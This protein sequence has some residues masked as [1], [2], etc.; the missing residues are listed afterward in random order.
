LLLVA[1]FISLNSLFAQTGKFNY[2]LAKQSLFKKSE[3]GL[4]DTTE[5]T[6]QKQAV[7]KK[8]V[9]IGG[10]F[11]SF[12]GGL[13][14]PLNN[15]FANSSPAFGI[16]GRVEYSSYKIF[17]LVFGGEV[18]YFSYSGTDEFKTTNTLSIFN[19]KIFSYGICIEYT[20]AKMLNSSYT[21]PFVTIDIKSNSIRRTYDIDAVLNNVPRDESR[22]SVGAG[23][24]FTIFVLDFYVKYNYM[25]DYNNFGIYTKMKF[26]II[27]F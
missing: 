22:I 8:N 27:R 7:Q 6:K 15:F 3:S 23:I 10:V 9:P 14:I 13:N 19:T 17:P 21:I 18:T 24:G 16:L 12:G 26:P 1:L 25:K 5:P 20:L 2:S 11:V 4:T